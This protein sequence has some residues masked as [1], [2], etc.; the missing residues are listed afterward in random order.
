M[1]Y[2]VHAVSTAT[3]TGTVGSDWQADT[4]TDALRLACS[5]RRERAALRLTVFVTDDHGRV[6]YT[7]RQ[8]TNHF[9]PHRTE[10]V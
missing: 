9:K 8:L 5:V 1:N 3:T 4:L 2:T 6:V 7:A 10:Y